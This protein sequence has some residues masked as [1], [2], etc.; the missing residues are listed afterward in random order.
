MPRRSH[1]ST[2]RPLLLDLFCKAGGAARG[3]ADAGFHVVGVDHLPQP[4]YPFELLL[5][6]ALD[7]LRA[8]GRDFDAVHASPPC[9]LYSAA[10]TIRGD[11]GHPD[12][13]GPTRDALRRLGRPYVI[14]NVPGAPLDVARTVVLCGYALGLRQYRHRLFETSFPVPQPRH[15]PH[16]VPQTKLGRPPRDGEFLQVVGNFSGT[17]RARRDLECPWMTR[18]ELREAVPPRYTRFVGGWLLRYL[19]S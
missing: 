7:A 9:Q 8:Y 1:D 5:D 17:A 10:Q 16:L 14:E 12:L 19:R 2:Y 13:I 18:D 11:D 3:Y 6:D 4:R 15:R